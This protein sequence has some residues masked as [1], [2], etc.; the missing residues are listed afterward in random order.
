[1]PTLSSEVALL[2]PEQWSLGCHR[3]AGRLLIAACHTCLHLQPIARCAD[4][5]TTR[6]LC[7]WTQHALRDAFKANKLLAETTRGNVAGN[8]TNGEMSWMICLVNQ[9]AH[10]A[11]WQCRNRS[12][13]DAARAECIPSRELPP[14]LSPESRSSLTSS[15]CSRE[16]G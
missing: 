13:G 14:D 1:M 8:D 2:C 5:S 9:Y 16:A 3:E 6:D 15:V 11:H 4:T 10:V 7:V 12:V